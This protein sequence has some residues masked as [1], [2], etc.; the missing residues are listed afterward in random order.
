MYL[1]I[2]TVGIGSSLTVIR[3][4][5]IIVLFKGTMHTIRT[6]NNSYMRTTRSFLQMIKML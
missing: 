4:I 3:S 5:T 1:N 2:L 6:Y